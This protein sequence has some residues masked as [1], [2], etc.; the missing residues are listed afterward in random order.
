MYST[1]ILQIQFFEYLPRWLAPALLVTGIALFLLGYLR[2]FGPWWAQNWLGSAL[3]VLGGVLIVLEA[4]PEFTSVLMLLFFAFAKWFEGVGV[5]RIYRIIVG[6]FST[7]QS[8]GSSVTKHVYK[9]LLIGFIVL[10][11]AWAIV[12]TVIFGPFQLPLENEIAIIWTVTIVLLAVVGMGFKLRSAAERLPLSLIAGFTLAAAGTEI[13]SLSLLGIAI[14]PAPSLI[15]G[16]ALSLKISYDLGTILLG[17]AALAIGFWTSALMWISPEV[18]DPASVG[19]YYGEKTKHSRTLLEGD[20]DGN[21]WCSVDSLPTGERGEDLVNS[22]YLVIETEYVGGTRPANEYPEEVR[23]IALCVLTKYLHSP[24]L[25]YGRKVEFLREKGHIEKAV[26]R[27]IDRLLDNGWERSE[28]ISLG[29]PTGL[30]D[31]GYSDG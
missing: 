6:F 22:S 13:Y 30:I 12:L 10:L 31:G 18:L 8:D 21:D 17:Q 19:G 27:E 1:L 7:S 11:T 24:E 2:T 26:T 23:V 25:E 16:G 3:T 28:F 9:Y 15:D 20:E 4:I 5:I 14:S 29:I